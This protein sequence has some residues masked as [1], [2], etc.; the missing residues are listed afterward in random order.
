MTP[1]VET[2]M[3]MN[4]EESL[5]WQLGW[6]KG[7]KAG[8]NQALENNSRKSLSVEKSV[9]IQNGKEMTNKVSVDNSRTTHSDT[10]NQE[11]KA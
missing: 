3:K 2:P 7:Y 9:E 1:K 6:D 10:D 11:V 8:Y 4:Y 5:A